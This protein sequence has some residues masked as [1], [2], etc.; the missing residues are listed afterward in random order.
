MTLI[1]T[2]CFILFCLLV[3]SCS[4]NNTNESKEKPE[5][6]QQEISDSTS[7][8]I[9]KKTRNNINHEVFYKK[10]L[11]G[12][13][14]LS[15]IR[16]ALTDKDIG[17]LTNTIHALYNYRWH[18][19]VTNLLDD[20]WAL[21]KKNAP[22]I[23]WELF[24]KIPIKLALAST[25]NRIKI[26]NT[27]EYKNY[28]HKHK[29]DEHEF[30]RAQVIIALSFN[31]DPKDV[32]YLEEMADGENHYVTQTAISGLGIMGGEKAKKAL[33]KLWRKYKETSRGN[34]IEEVLLNA[35]G[36]T[37]TLEKPLDS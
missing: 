20:M 15:D 36:V 3:S 35:Y 13:A 10:I 19:G 18:R 7:K 27:E 4:E 24:E 26:F 23:S 16:Q 6:K 33:G 32:E 5:V 14:N 37:P 30:H 1:R 29:Y 8:N 2:S 21:K 11:Y 17:R 22:E 9:P 28:L 31:A 12:K 25:I 34:L